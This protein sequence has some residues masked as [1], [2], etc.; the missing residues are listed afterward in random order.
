MVFNKMDRLNA[1]DTDVV[2]SMNGVIGISALN[3]Q[4]ARPLLEEIE[5]KLWHGLTE[6]VH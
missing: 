6:S 2:Q 5:N 4:T 3:P 1:D